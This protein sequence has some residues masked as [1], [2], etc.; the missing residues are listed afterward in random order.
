MFDLTHEPIEMYTLLALGVAAVCLGLPGL[1]VRSREGKA[2]AHCP[3]ALTLSLALGLAAGGTAAAG[4]PPFVWLPPLALA[5]VWLLFAGL[6]AGLLGSVSFFAARLASRPRAQS[7]ALVLAGGSLLA[8]Q[9]F[10]L[11]RDVNNDMSETDAL[12]AVISSA[13]PLEVHPTVTA[14]TDAGQHIPLW[15]PVGTYPYDDLGLE[16]DFLHQH[17]FDAKVIRTAAPDITHNCHG[18]VFL[19]GKGWIRG[20]NVEQILRDNHYEIVSLPAPGD[21]AV[22]R[23]AAGV[24][25][26][27][28]LVRGVNDD[29]TVLMESKWG[30]LGRYIH[31]AS[32]HAYAH[33]SCTYYHANRGSHT[34]R[35][36]AEM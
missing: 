2:R 25:S 7:A 36:S 14:R 35:L 34:L 29:G 32:E 28:A 9:S 12:L 1:F 15:R 13:P 26:H 19:G 8:W 31:T 6:R 20:R 30:K 18:W 21:V 22:Y 23:D 24:V 11:T 3:R 16:S 27:T 4:L 17:G 5:G 10:A 33:D